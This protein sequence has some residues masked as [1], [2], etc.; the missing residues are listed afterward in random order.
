[1]CSTLSALQEGTDVSQFPD[2][3][4]GRL[5]G[6]RVGKAE[7]TGRKMPGGWILV[8]LD[9]GKRRWRDHP[10]LKSRLKSG[11]WN[12]GYAGTPGLGVTSRLDRA[13]MPE[14]RRNECSLYG[15]SRWQSSGEL[16]IP[17]F[18]SELRIISGVLF[19]KSALP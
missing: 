13:I 1:M 2:G 11:I 3:I 18:A 6:P 16:Q 19:R 10:R 5:S 15:T 8:K 14:F 7:L 17:L 9:L 12:A 4:L